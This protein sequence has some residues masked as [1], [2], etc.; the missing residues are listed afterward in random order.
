MAQT[1]DLLETKQCLRN[2]NITQEK[3]P[4]VNK[5]N[6]ELTSSESESESESELSL[7]SLFFL[8]GLA[9]VSWKY[10]ENVSITL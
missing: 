4:R 1:K 6:R 7:D 10:I 5:Y 8:T 3:L 9:V 2:T